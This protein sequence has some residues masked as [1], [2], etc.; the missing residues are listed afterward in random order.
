MVIRNY[1]TKL[2]LPKTTNDPSI[3]DMYLYYKKEEEEKNGQDR[4]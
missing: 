1:L 3:C 2:E 4:F